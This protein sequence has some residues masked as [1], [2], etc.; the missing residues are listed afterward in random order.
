MGSSQILLLI[1]ALVILGLA[2][3][4]GLDLFKVNRRQAE[5]DRV[6]IDI[7]R[8]AHEI[9]VWK[10]Q[11]AELDGG[12]DTDLSEIDFERIYHTTGPC[13]AMAG[14]LGVGETC[15][16]QEQELRYI[17]QPEDASVRVVALSRDIG[18]PA[19]DY[20]LAEALVTG[21][22]PEDVEITIVR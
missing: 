14:P 19:R 12:R 1:L 22:H 13:D 7:N 20:R 10:I 4:T 17:L 18:D 15:Y 6:T 3:A 21:I 11:P 16:F 8:I 2:L 9:Q 5:M